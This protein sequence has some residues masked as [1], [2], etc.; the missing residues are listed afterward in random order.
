[1]KNFIK[2]TFAVALISTFCPQNAKSTQATTNLTYATP[3]EKNDIG[4][5]AEAPNLSLPNAQN[6]DSELKTLRG[7]LTLISFWASYEPTGRT[8]NKK[9]ATLQNQYATTTL[10]EGIGLKVFAV[11]L[12]G[13]K[14]EWQ[15]AIK[16]DDIANFTN[17]FDIYSSSVNV[18]K[19]T[20]MP[21][22]FLVDEKGYI[23][24]HNISSEK[25]AEILETKVQATP[26]PTTKKEVIAT[27]MPTA[28]N[29][30][31]KAPIIY[32][33]SRTGTYTI[34]KPNIT[35]IPEPVTA[36]ANNDNAS[37]AEAVNAITTNKNV[38]PPPTAEVPKTYNE[39]QKQRKV[40]DITPPQ[41]VAPTQNT[42]NNPK[43]YK[44]QLGAFKN[45]KLSDYYKFSE[46]GNISTETAPNGIK[47]IMLGEYN[48]IEAKQ[49]LEKVK[50][51]GYNDAFMVLNKTNAPAAA[52]STNTTPQKLV[53]VSDKTSLMPP[54]PTHTTT[55]ETI[56]EKDNIIPT[57]YQS[58][59]TQKTSTTTIYTP[60]VAPNSTTTNANNNALP[61]APSPPVTTTY[62][63]PPPPAPCPQFVKVIPP[64]TPAIT[65]DDVIATYGSFEDD[66]PGNEKV[67]YTA[68]TVVGEQVSAQK[69][70][71]SNTA[72]Y[73]GTATA[74]S[75]SISE[76]YTLPA[77][78]IYTALPQGTPVAT[79]TAL[80]Q[81]TT[82]TT[83]GAVVYKPNTSPLPTA[84]AT[85]AANQ[86]EKN[87]TN[88][89]VTPTANTTTTPNSNRL[90]NVSD[91]PATTTPAP[92]P[93][94]T[95]NPATD[96]T[97]NSNYTSQD[98]KA[99]SDAID[100]YF[101]KNEYLTI[102]GKVK[103]KKLQRKE[104]KNKK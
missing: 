74:P 98:A 70:V 44:I 53:P 2:L 34:T 14:A 55:T 93:A 91:R 11:S 32:G 38:T 86:K 40:A 50:I 80:P 71:F 18:Y 7:N 8:F 46:L 17:V 45:P 59:S 87:N 100:I 78:T 20:N 77:T 97:V 83:S 3:L 56:T 49:I 37:I 48:E 10:G 52:P 82:T 13:D 15:Q 12:D 33:N 21:T 29:K 67:V 42:A 90:Q 27:V 85:T 66:V 99:L 4:I 61:T 76:V 5:G 25:L 73:N 43:T 51:M 92:A 101:Q 36:S 41:N 19:L 26:P 58:Q 88:N 89:A 6:L 81:G 22:N 23:V 60:S 65:T 103:S 28:T 102:D 54:A 47:R 1:M 39:Q 79:Y 16:T 35:A 62:T 24:A 104:R 72:N 63:A 94:T 69:P 57:T 64:A 31:T 9:I 75:G 96:G 68:Q 30:D 84:P 95:T